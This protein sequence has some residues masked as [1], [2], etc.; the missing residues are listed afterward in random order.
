MRRILCFAVALILVVQVWG[1]EKGME[2][3]RMI[4]ERM[5]E[6]LA[7]EGNEAAAEEIA[8]HFERLLYKP[9]DLNSATRED[10]EMLGILSDFQIESLLEYRKRS[11]NILSAT[12]LQLVN[13]FHKGVVEILRPFITFGNRNGETYNGTKG[14]FNSTALL[15]WWWKEG[16]ENYIGPPF[17]SQIKYSAEASGKIRGGFTLEKDAGEKLSGKGRLPLGDF[18]SFHIGVENVPLGRKAVLKNALLGD[19]TIRL[20]QGL[21]VWNSFTLGGDLPVQS[22][23]RRGYAAAPYTSSDE[24]KFLRGGAVTFGNNLGRFT[25]LETTLFFSLKNVDARISGDKYTSLPADGLHNTGSLLET[26]K[27]LGEIVYGGSVALK[28]EKMKVGLNYIGYGYNALNG[29]K[30]QEYNRYQMYDG[31]YGNFSIDASAVMGKIRLFAE[32]AVD[33]GGNIALLCGI[34]ARIAGWETSLI[35][36]NYPR[37]Y[38]AP[39]AGAHSVGSSCS[40]QEGAMLSFQKVLGKGR[41]SGGGSYT[42]FPHSRYGIQGPSSAYRIWCKGESSTAFGGWDLK[43]YMKGGRE[44]ASG[45]AT[46]KFGA[47]GS[48]KRVFCEWIWL[49]LK[50]EASVSGDGTNGYAA[51]IDTGLKLW[52]ENV[53]LV[54]SSAYMNCRDWESRIYMYEYDLPSSYVSKLMFGKGFW[55]YALLRYRIW[56]NCTLHLKADGGSKIK[57]GLKMRFF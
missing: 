10:L 40:N 26:R 32:A 41:Y 9:L 39:Y 55:W 8:L 1:Q 4:M 50:G 13:G 17:Y 56:R 29:R 34:L 47:K 20:G 21:A 49:R 44:A 2:A 51:A 14:G 18:F 46:S 52:K 7:E 27:R 11:G 45:E 54:L 6:E 23:Y 19:Y 28:S 5:A 53:E 30:V 57:I 43:L 16:E 35:Y 31:Q 33:Y 38:I 12:E 3:V 24:N 48:L 25:D 22:T 36:R 15:K 37:G 42:Y